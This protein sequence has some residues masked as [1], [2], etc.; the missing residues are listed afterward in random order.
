MHHMADH[1]ARD[2]PAEE[3]RHIGIADPSIPMKFQLGNNR[4]PARPHP[5]KLVEDQHPATRFD[6]LAYSLEDLSPC[7]G[8][9][10]HTPGLAREV[11]EK[12]IDLNACAFALDTLEVENSFLVRNS[13]TNQRRFSDMTPTVDHDQLRF[14][15]IAQT[16]TNQVELMCPSHKHD[17]ALCHC[18]N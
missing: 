9:K 8:A 6:D 3:E 17:A 2:R 10:T 18:A 5:R 14:Q 11:V 12:L 15:S 1:E 16:L 13:L 4:R 7:P